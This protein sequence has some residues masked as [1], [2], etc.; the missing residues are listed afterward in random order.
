MVF[1]T[2]ETKIPSIYIVNEHKLGIKKVVFAE[3]L[4]PGG[5]STQDARIS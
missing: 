3:K 1:E 4:N 5:T 2:T